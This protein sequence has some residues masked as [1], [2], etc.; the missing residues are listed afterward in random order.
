MSE[1][2]DVYDITLLRHGESVGNA[3]GVIQGQQDYPLSQVGVQQAKAL[4]AYWLARGVTMERII[5]S[6]LLRARQ[7][8]EIISAAFEIE[9]VLDPAWTERDYG[10]ISGLTQEEYTKRYPGPPP[11]L[12]PYAPFGLTGESKWDLFLRAGKAI[13]NLLTKEP[14]R[15]LVV[16]HGGILNIA[17]YAILGIPPQTGSSGPRFP[18]SNTGFT[19]LSY[20]PEE[21]S[22]R[23]LGFNE[24]PH[25][26]SEQN[27]EGMW[28][29]IQGSKS[30]ENPRRGKQ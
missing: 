7:T 1:T 11:L 13:Q 23:L 10:A 2:W 8:A 27:Q 6:P 29:V 30:H 17:M 25:W 21:H 3:S 20:R 28:S 4:A 19:R 5:S 22:W 12:H 15:I 24:H 18:H 14:G 9:V 26:T 16:S